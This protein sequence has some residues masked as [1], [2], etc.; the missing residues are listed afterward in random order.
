[1][2]Y[3]VISTDRFKKDA[4]RLLKKYKSLKADLSL[5]LDELEKNQKWVFLLAI[6]VEKFV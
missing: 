6:I 5:L 2:S 3:N 4:K 1:M